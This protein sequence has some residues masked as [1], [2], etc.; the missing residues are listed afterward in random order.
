MFTKTAELHDD[1]A[2]N[3]IDLAAQQLSIIP[4]LII[5]IIRRI[6][7]SSETGFIAYEF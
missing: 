3:L 4:R 1:A 5:S 2:D 7:K 6:S